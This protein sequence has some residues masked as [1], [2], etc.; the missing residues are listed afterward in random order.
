ME[1]DYEVE[2]DICVDTYDVDAFDNIQLNSEECMKWL[3]CS[4]YKICPGLE[5][6]II[7]HMVVTHNPSSAIP[8]VFNCLVFGQG[9]TNV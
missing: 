4:L 7:F 5:I 3:N 2:R 6:Q 8:P 1:E 9:H